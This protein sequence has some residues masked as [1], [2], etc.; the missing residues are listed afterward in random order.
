MKDK[1]I[2][3]DFDGTITKRDSFLPLVFFFATRMWRHY[4]LLP[5]LLFFLM[6]KVN[7]LSTFALK[8][9]FAFFFLRG[10]RLNQVKRLT[11]RFWHTKFS[12]FVDPEILSIFYKNL[13]E[14][15]RVIINSASFAFVVEEFCEFLGISAEVLGTHATIRGEYFTGKI[16]E[17]CRGKIKVLRLHR[18]IGN[19]DNYFI[20]VFSDNS[21][22][23]P[24]F[25]V[26][27]IAYKVERK[28]KKRNIKVINYKGVET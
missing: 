20:E 26:A 13:K 17:E 3:F 10:R 1:L 14:R 7:L 28:G 27:D 8:K 25:S 21:S 5:F 16:G 12:A 2:V 9:L 24:L 11:S 23:V 15:N 19:G 18:L 4:L 6:Y 22:D